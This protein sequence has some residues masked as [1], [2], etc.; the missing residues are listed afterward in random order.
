MA[1]IAEFS[2]GY[3][4]TIP[5]SVLLHFTGVLKI[6]FTFKII[7]RLVHIKNDSVLYLYRYTYSFSSF[8]VYFVGIFHNTEYNLSK[9]F[10]FLI[11]IV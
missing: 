4:F 3:T 9:K 2:A 8:W 10:K 5:G 6:F 1:S 11:I 7:E